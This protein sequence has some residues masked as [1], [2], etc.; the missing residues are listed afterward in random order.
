MSKTETE[1]VQ[2][3]SLA[4]DGM[5]GML[6]EQWI[7]NGELPNIEAARET[8]S[9]GTAECSSLSSAKQWTTHFTGVGSDTHG[10]QGFLRSGQKRTAGD[11]APD[12]SELINLSDIEVKTYPELLAEDGLSVGLLNPLPI[13][14]PLSLMRDSA[15]LDCLP[16]QRRMI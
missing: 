12:A 6:L 1:P 16:H 3:I 10:V 11:S 7:A 8:G 14:P 4:V 5:E 2:M 15:L 13:W 9:H